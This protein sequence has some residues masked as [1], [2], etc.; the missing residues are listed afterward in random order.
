MPKVGIMNLQPILKTLVLIGFLQT[1]AEIY[2]HLAISGSQQQKNIAQDLGMP[3]D[4]VNRHLKRLLKRQIVIVSEEHPMRFKA[5]PFEEMLNH[6]KDASLEDA[7]RLEQQK[8]EALEIWRTLVAR[9][10]FEHV[11]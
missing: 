10:R 7:N 5:A 8:Q 9:T 6:F 11:S 2:L 3:K 4:Q 1:D